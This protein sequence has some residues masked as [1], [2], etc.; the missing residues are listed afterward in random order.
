MYLKM[1]E[2]SRPARTITSIFAG[3]TILTESGEILSY[4]ADPREYF[5]QPSKTYLLVLGY[6]P[7]INS[8]RFAKR[9]GLIDRDR[10]RR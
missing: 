3:G 1:Q 8:Y 2:V 7:V 5:V 6:D 9:L 4:M 10:Q